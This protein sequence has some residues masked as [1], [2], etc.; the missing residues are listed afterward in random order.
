MTWILDL[1]FDRAGRWP[2][3]VLLGIAAGCGTTRLTDT[4]RTAT[5][6]LV[7][8]NAID[9][10]VTD[11]DFQV[12]AGKPVYFDAQYLDG[13]VDKGYL[14]SSLRQQLLAAGCLLQEDRAKAVYVVEARSGGVGTNRHALLVGVPQ[15]NVPTLVPGQP[16]Q[17][18]E[19]PLAKKT[20]QEGIAKVAL[21]AYN[22]LTG[23]PVWQSGVVQ[24]RSTAADTWV[25]GA[26]PFQAGTIRKG[27][28]FAGQPISL[29][30]FRSKEPAEVDTASKVPATDAAVW[31]ESLAPNNDSLRLAAAPGLRSTDERLKI[32]DTDQLVMA[33]VGG[34]QGAPTMADIPAVPGTSPPVAGPSAPTNPL[35]A[36]AKP[37][38]APAATANKGGA[39]ETEPSN[40]FASGLVPRPGTP[41]K[42]QPS[43][44][45]DTGSA[46]KPDGS[47]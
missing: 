11:L 28:A 43:R 14:V 16:A 9:Q 7:V 47:K 39:A 31:A 17:I 1:L 27:T 45:S 19:I 4:Q 8:S 5:E 35:A 30:Q 2:V 10:V 37:A 29:P 24:A 46:P 33:M 36:P 40:V 34:E 21:F 22:R 26:G 32:S 20:D 42:T 12:L 38:P 25:L 41:A 15:M 18:P 23:Q 44:N 6:Q 13:V 3:M